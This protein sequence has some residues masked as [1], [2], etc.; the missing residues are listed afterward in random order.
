MQPALSKPKTLF[1]Y[2]PQYR[3][4]MFF[5]SDYASNW[6]KISH[7][8]NHSEITV[9]SHEDL[10][11]VSQSQAGRLW[12]PTLQQRLPSRSHTI[13]VCALGCTRC[14]ER[15]E[16]DPLAFPSCSRI[17]FTD[18]SPLQFQHAEMVQ[19]GSAWFKRFHPEWDQ[20][21]E[22]IQYDS[23]KQTTKPQGTWGNGQHV[24]LEES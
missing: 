4:T 11:L 10:I 9:K 17:D 21:I 2:L 13:P 14:P 3:H 5:E 12:K 18:I 1:E 7:W 24:R 19:H 15:P 6:F 16:H 23:T 8:Y 20:V 22:W